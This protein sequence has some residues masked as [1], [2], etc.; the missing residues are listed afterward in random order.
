MDLGPCHLMPWHLE[1]NHLYLYLPYLTVNKR[2]VIENT[3]PSRAQTDESRPS[4]ETLKCHFPLR[5]LTQKL[6]SQW[7]HNDHN[8]TCIQEPTLYSSELWFA[9]RIHFQF[10]DKAMEL[11]KRAVSFHGRLELT[12]SSWIGSSSHEEAAE[13]APLLRSSSSKRPGW[14]EGR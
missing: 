6:M 2:N 7:H 12:G 1:T 8:A 10:S 11:P 5:R 4:T 3:W 13:V 14:E 9:F